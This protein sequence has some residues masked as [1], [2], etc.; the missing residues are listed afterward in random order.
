M[1]G[2]ILFLAKATVDGRR[3]GRVRDERVD[4]GAKALTMRDGKVETPAG[5]GIA[6]AEKSVCAPIDKWLRLPCRVWG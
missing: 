1:I 5:A 3:N 2:A 4:V 6:E